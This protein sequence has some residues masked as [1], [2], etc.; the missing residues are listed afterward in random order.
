VLDQSRR[1]SESKRLAALD[2][3]FKEL[4][5]RLNHRVES[6]ADCHGHI[7]GTHQCVIVCLNHH[8]CAVKGDKGISWRET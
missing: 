6:K 2:D 4:D 7:I 5:E 1:I 3:D 8:V